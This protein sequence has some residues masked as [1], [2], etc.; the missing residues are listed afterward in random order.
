MT[1]KEVQDEMAEMQTQTSVVRIIG[2]QTVPS[3]SN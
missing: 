2:Q 3:A 1:A